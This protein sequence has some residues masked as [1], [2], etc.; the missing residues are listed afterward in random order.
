[1]PEP[2]FDLET[3]ARARRLGDWMF[4]Q[5]EPHLGPRAMEVGPGIGTFSERLLTHGVE[6]LLLLE[7][8]D[9]CARELERRFGGD[10]RVRIER[11]G[12]PDAPA[13]QTAAE[14]LDFVLCQNVLEHIDEEEATVS[15]M[16]RA[17][18]PG[19]ALGLLVPAHPRLYGSLDRHY[20]HHRRYTRERVRRLL[21][22]AGL[23]EVSLRS[24][25][26]LG[27]AGWW[28]KCRLGST[29]LDARSMAVYERLLPFWRPLEDALRPPWGLSLV[30][31][32]RR[33][34]PSS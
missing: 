19:G 12:L 16:A 7:P 20:G 24:F 13:L 25:N 22:D 5:F 29:T 14:A 27:V 21:A 9:V 2:L 23:A 6:D 8:D 33:L 4:A 28:T 1:M 3:L 11:H 30:A 31:V 10:P 17:L 34:D 15:A 32:A 18:R 26:L